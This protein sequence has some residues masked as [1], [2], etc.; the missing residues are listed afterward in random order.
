LQGAKPS[1]LSVR[2]PTKFALVTLVG[3]RAS[4]LPVQARR[5]LMDEGRKTR[6]QHRGVQAALHPANNIFAGNILVFREN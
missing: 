5:I 1:R 2:Q 3:S 4:R 6:P